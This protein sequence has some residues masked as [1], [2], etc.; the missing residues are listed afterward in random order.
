MKSIYLILIS[1]FLL[2]ACKDRIDIDYSVPEGAEAGNFTKVETTLNEEE[3]RTIEYWK[4]VVPE[5]R[6]NTNTRLISLPVKIIRSFSETPSEPLYYLTGGPGISNLSYRP[7]DNILAERDVVLVGYRGVD[8]TVSLDCADMFDAPS[9]KNLFDPETTQVMREKMRK[10]VDQLKEKGVDLKG[11]TMLEVIEDVED[12]RQA[13]GHSKI[14]LLSAS[15]GTRLAQ[16][17]AYQYPQNVHRSIMVS[18]NPPGHFVW[19][20]ETLD[21]Q[22]N[23]YSRL[24]EQDPY[25]S[26]R[27]DNLAETL[28]SVNHNMP[29]RWLFFKIDPD[30][31]RM[32]AFMGLYHRGS[33][34]SVFDTYIAAE[35]GDPSGL[36]L[37]SVM[38]GIQISMMDFAWGDSYAKAF[39]DFDPDRN[40]PR[41]MA[42]GESIMGSPGSQTFATMDAWP[43]KVL[44]KKFN[45]PQLSEVETLL[46]S[47][48]IDFS[49]PAEFARDELLPF[50]PN[51]KQVILSVMGHTGDVM[52]FNPE[53][54]NH[55]VTN[56]LKSGKVD[57][58]RFETVPMNFEPEDR[59]Q[60]MAKIGLA[61]LV[62]VSILLVWLIWLVYRK[63]RKLYLKYR[64]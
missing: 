34:A 2:T 59:F 32:A 29:K 26:S 38:F 8:G 19:E 58:S 6:S 24:C 55:L 15:Y 42:L 10:C 44:P 11:Y 31:V 17:Y 4:I 61:L 37:L 41:D 9:G 48:D 21:R 1:T 49:T 54:F 57:D 18:V 14:N 50:L 47:G 25:C 36:A 27:T 16:F 64:R 63:G 22:I 12:V 45:E 35:R 28:R 40:Y 3:N 13:I 7:H 51:G 60:S 56:Y 30:K 52:R 5:N 53:A 33:A 20:S 39:P 43:G 46:V 62:F 23:Y